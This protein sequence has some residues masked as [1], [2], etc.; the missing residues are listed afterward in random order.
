MDEDVAAVEPLPIDQQQDQVLTYEADWEILPWDLIA[1]QSYREVMT[2]IWSVT[3]GGHNLSQLN[4][5]ERL[6]EIGITFSHRKGSSTIELRFNNPS[7]TLQDKPV[8]QH[9]NLVTVVWGYEGG[10]MSRQINGMISHTEPDFPDSGGTT[11]TVYATDQTQTLDNILEP[12]ILEGANRMTPLEIIRRFMAAR[13]PQ[14]E[15]RL[16][17]EKGGTFKGNDPFGEFNHSWS[18]LAMPYG[19]PFNVEA[20]ES[21]RQALKRLAKNISLDDES[22]VGGWHWY[23]RGGVLHLVPYMMNEQPV[24]GYIYGVDPVGASFS[25]APDLRSKNTQTEAMSTVVTE[26]GEVSDPETAVEDVAGVDDNLIAEES[27]PEAN[28][29]EGRAGLHDSALGEEGSAAGLEAAN[30]IVSHDANKV[31]MAIVVFGEPRM[32]VGHGLAL[33]GLGQTY[34]GVWM[35]DEVQHRLSRSGAKTFPHVFRN[36]LPIPATMSKVKS[37]YPSPHKAIRPMSKLNPSGI[38]APR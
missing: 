17:M 24:F 28:A 34:D 10:A 14:I 37:K 22:H 38:K 29:P 15:L 36:A 18:V 25:F 30:E 2:P 35:T 23:A 26:D 4:L 5:S 20:G 6:I 1:P 21:D 8:F 3:I 33:A 31:Q 19:R 16:P 11:L 9:G 7:R 27:N 12:W 32:E 13:H